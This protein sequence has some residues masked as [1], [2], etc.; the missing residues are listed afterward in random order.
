VFEY[1]GDKIAEYK[2]YADVS[3]LYAE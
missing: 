3:P 1:E 2:I